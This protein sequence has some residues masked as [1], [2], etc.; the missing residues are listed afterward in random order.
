MRCIRWHNRYCDAVIAQEDPFYH[1]KFKLDAYMKRLI[2]NVLNA[3][4]KV[5]FD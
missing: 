4:E 5:E 3:K 1:N 2:T